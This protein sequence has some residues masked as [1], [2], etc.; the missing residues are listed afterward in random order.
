MFEPKHKTNV[1]TLNPLCRVLSKCS[2]I[3]NVKNL[4]L[5]IFVV[6]AK[7]SN[8]RL[9]PTSISSVW[10]GLSSRLNWLTAVPFCFKHK[11]YFQLSS[12]K[13]RR[14]DVS[15]SIT[16]LA[17]HTLVLAHTH[18][19]CCYS[20]I[21]RQIPFSALPSQLKKHQTHFLMLPVAQDK[22]SFNLLFLLLSFY[23]FKSKFCSGLK[24]ERSHWKQ[25]N[26]TRILLLFSFFSSQV[27]SNFYCAAKPGQV[28]DYRQPCL[29]EIIQDEVPFNG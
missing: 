5:L 20:C 26:R 19:A 22:T 1:F 9:T 18:T 29:H 14:E 2:A 25:V 17:A 13:N 6:R 27:L 16:H 23:F 15:A 12:V 21:W 24:Q 10:N 7:P 4:Y 11:S 28:C 3:D 8:K